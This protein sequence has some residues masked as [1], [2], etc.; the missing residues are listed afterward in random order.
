[1][2]QHPC[3]ATHLSDPCSPLV[4][5]HA[6]VADDPFPSTLVYMGLESR[7][8]SHHICP[9]LLSPAMLPCFGG[10]DTAS[11]CSVPAPSSCIALSPV[12]P[13]CSAQLMT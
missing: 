13:V 9:L 4:S 10:A 8:P 3:W 6:L 2:G 5:C 7:N 12:V 11:L 1:M